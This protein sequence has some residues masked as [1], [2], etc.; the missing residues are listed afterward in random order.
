MRLRFR[1][2]ASLAVTTMVSASLLTA[3]ASAAPMAAPSGPDVSSWQHPGGAAINWAKVK[4]AGNAFAIIK[5]TEG[6]AYTNPYF[7]RDTQGARSVSLVVGAY[8][9]VRPAL[10]IS[11]AATQAQHFAAT[12]GNVAS[13]GTLPPILDL[14][15]SGGLAPGDL[16]TWAQTFLETVRGLTGRTPVV[17]SYPYFWSSAMAGS[18]AFSRYP[19]WLAAYRTTVPTPLA[20]WPAW[21]LWQYS[22]TASV[23]GIPGAGAIDMSRFAGT[24]AQLDVVA[25]GRLSSSWPVSAPSAPVGVAARARIRAATVSWRPADDGGQL[26]TSYAVTVS[27][28]GATTTVSGTTTSVTLPGLSPGIG[29]TFTVAATNRA[30]RSTS[31]QPSIAVVPGQLPSIP[32]GPPSLTAGSGAVTVAWQPASG[33]PTS[34]RIYRCSPAPCNPPTS[35]MAIV[36]APANSYVD[37]ALSNGTSYA[38]TVAAA[39]V[40]GSSGRTRVA[41]A[42]PVGPPPVPTG[43]TAKPSDVSVTLGW[44]PPASTGGAPIARYVVTKDGRAVATLPFTARSYLATGL[45]NGETH[46]FGVAA[47]SSLGTGPAARVTTAAA[48]PLAP[49]RVTIA[50][51]NPVVSGRALTVT[52]RAVR[53]DTGASLAGL[54]VTVAMSPRAGAAPAVQRLVTDAGGAATATVQPSVTGTITARLSPSL[55]TAASVVSVLVQ[56]RPGLPVTLSTP[57]TTLHQPVVLSGSTSSLLA[58]ERLYEQ[59]YDAGAWRTVAS[60]LIDLTGRYRFVV[61]PTVAGSS[62]L[63]LWLRASGLHLAAPSRTVTLTVRP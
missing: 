36:A 57:I 11:T 18:T 23:D 39:N 4:G 25:D 45:V 17:Y 49:T 21:A 50:M 46:V 2:A 27:P 47:G 12:L 42:T 13:V 35:A 32:P 40:W 30:G 7:A 37:R 20:G 24:K 3:T 1:L 8:A 38:Y 22:A 31:S 33:S 41:A 34:Y 26:P 9:Y 55:R 19:L 16:I 28:G 29:Y 10:P 48:S 14:E 15:E 54:P 60:T 62:P 56:V 52:V 63:R 44:T 5:A 53:A 61:T 43:L 58:G 59:Q 51:P 6:P